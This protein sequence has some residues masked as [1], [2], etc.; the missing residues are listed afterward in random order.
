[1][2][3]SQKETSHKVHLKCPQTTKVV[4]TGYFIAETIG[5]PDQNQG[6]YDLFNMSQIKTNLKNT[7][8]V[9]ILMKIVK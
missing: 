6:K 2:K 1:M 7:V 4:D 8:D 9:N 3:K 5:N